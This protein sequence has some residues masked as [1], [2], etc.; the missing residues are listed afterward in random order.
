MKR[1]IY[2]ALVGINKA[3][4]KKVFNFLHVGKTGGSAIKAA[5]NNKG[6]YRFRGNLFLFHNHPVRFNQIKRGEKVFFVI[7]DPLSRFVSGF[8]SRK[9]Q[10][11]P[12]IFNPWKKGEKEAFECFVS[13]NS[14]G[15][16]LGDADPQY[17]EQAIAAM[18][19][20]GHVN[21]SFWDWFGDENYLRERMGDIM[22][23]GTQEDLTMEFEAFK[24]HLS[25]PAGIQLPRDKTNM[26]KNPEHLDK[27]LSLTAQ[28]HLKNW[29]QEDYKFLSL[30]L[31]KKLITRDY[32]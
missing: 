13:P 7:R 21:T 6:L 26:H 24:D 15:E 14:L 20:I 1:I 9:R 29:Y 4:S 11:M 22:W 32:R 19:A 18:K 5:F 25:L 30:L 2:E 27:K 12:R 3:S 31:E 16:A 17:R 8:Y 23:V 28:K 10:G